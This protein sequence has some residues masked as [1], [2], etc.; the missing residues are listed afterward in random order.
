[1]LIVYFG[2]AERIFLLLMRLFFYTF[3]IGEGDQFLAL[4]ALLDESGNVEVVLDL[5]DVE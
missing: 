2:G 5:E 3:R 4:E 1:M